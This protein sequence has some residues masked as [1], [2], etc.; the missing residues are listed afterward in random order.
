MSKWSPPGPFRRG[1]ELRAPT[2]SSAGVPLLGGS[3]GPVLPASP[4]PPRPP[5]AS[6]AA[7]APARRPLARVCR[8]I[9][10][11]FAIGRVGAARS[12]AG[13]GLQRPSHAALS[14][15]RR[16]WGEGEP[17][18]L[19]LIRDATENEPLSRA[20]VWREGRVP[21]ASPGARLRAGPAS[22]QRKRSWRQPGSGGC[23][24]PG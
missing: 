21:R 17:A 11:D 8:G 15:K 1:A 16:C 24:G 10:P 18:G 14:R 6:A 19:Y 22:A 4:E 7:A 12:R 2:R 20:G 5:A 9:G 13:T 3:A 23:Q